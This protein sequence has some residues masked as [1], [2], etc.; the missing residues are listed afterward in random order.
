MHFYSILSV[1]LLILSVWSILIFFCA[2]RKRDE[3]TNSKVKKS[4]FMKQKFH[5]FNG[6]N[7][8][9]KHIDRFI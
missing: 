1:A 4:S 7:F 6:N 5:E 3:G 9:L 8:S 2:Q